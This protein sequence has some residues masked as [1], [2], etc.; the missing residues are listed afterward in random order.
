ME[1]ASRVE[2]PRR[3]GGRSASRT[4]QLEAL[5]SDVRKMVVWDRCVREEQ[6]RELEQRAA[7]LWRRAVIE[8][9][10]LF[11]IGMLITSG[12]GLSSLLCGVIGGAVVGFAWHLSRAGQLLAPMLSMTAFMFLMVLVGEA[13]MLVFFCAPFSFGAIAGIMALQRNDKTI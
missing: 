12:F 5:P 10:L 1:P 8:G 3:P 11:T 13:N 2:D 6:C 4:E 7:R 9:V